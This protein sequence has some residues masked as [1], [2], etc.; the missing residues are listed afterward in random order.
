MSFIPRQYNWVTG[1]TGMNTSVENKKLHLLCQ[2]ILST[3]QPTHAFPF[4]F[5]ILQPYLQNVNV[6][7]HISS[8]FSLADCISAFLQIFNQ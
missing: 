5:Q 8:L 1:I 3:D 7:K 2:T 6:G 4:F